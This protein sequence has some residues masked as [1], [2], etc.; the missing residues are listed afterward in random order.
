M[1]VKKTPK[2]AHRVPQ[3][4]AVIEEKRLAVST[5]FFASNMYLLQIQ[6]TYTLFDL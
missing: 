1:P 4:G 3:K 2:T 6:K 5:V